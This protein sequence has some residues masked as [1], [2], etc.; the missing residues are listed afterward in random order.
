MHVHKEL[1]IVTMV[2]IT[3]TLQGHYYKPISQ[4][5]N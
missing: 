2:N 5:E 4:V 1:N 3:Q